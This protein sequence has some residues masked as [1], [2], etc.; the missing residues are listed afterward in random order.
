[1]EFKLKL[2]VIATFTLLLAACSSTKSTQSEYAY[3]TNYSYS[4]MAKLHYR[5]A[6]T[7]RGY[8]YE[9]HQLVPE[10]NKYW[11]LLAKQC[12]P[13]IQSEGIDSFKFVFVVD[14]LGN[15]ID[16]KA[17]LDTKGVNCF[18]NGVQKI[19]YPVPP[20]ENWYELVSVR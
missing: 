17:E 15:V 9:A 4:D 5:Q 10:H 16:A 12:R 6:K 3:K 18:L 11:S 1:M 14:S 20:Y 8:Q 19:K 13:L 2:F 7:K